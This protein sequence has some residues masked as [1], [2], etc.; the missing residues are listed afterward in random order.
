MTLNIAYL[1]QGKLFLKSGDLPIQQIESSFGQEVIN[2]TVQRYQK[3]EWKTKGGQAS[4]F[5]G[6]AL[7]GVHEGDPGDLAAR[8]TGV[9][10]GERDDQMLYTLAIEGAGGLFLYDWSANQEKRLFHKE[11]FYIRDLDRHLDLGLV[12]CS[13]SL[14]NGTAHIGLI[15]GFQVQQVTE[16]DSVDEA[17]TW[18]PGPGKA[19]VFQSAGIARNSNGHPFG[20]GPFAVHRLNL[21]SGEMTSLLEDPKFDFLLPHLDTAGNLYFIRRPY[22]APGRSAYPIHKLLLDILLFPFRLTRAII[23]FLNAF[24]VLFS[25]KPLLTASGIKMEGPDERMIMLRGRIMDTQKI[26]RE[27]AQNKEAPY[28][29]PASWE[30]VRRSPASDE[31]VLAGHVVAFD[32]D[33]Q[34]RLVYTNGSAIYQLETDGQA[35]LLGKGHLIEDVMII[36]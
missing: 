6:S 28:L 18:I 7:W 27:S 21:E 8:I 23:H 12:A 25:K 10:R 17:P 24:S 35:R 4:P 33:S 32:L 34:G 3:K 9:T 1:S 19:L 26:L 11:Y 16:G 22:E 15:K 31:Q 2:R 14:P 20:L 5:G 13:Q 36:G 30:L 29:A